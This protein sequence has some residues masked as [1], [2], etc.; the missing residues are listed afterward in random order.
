M[1][2]PDMS[3]N[4][5]V[6]KN[7]ALGEPQLRSTPLRG[8]ECGLLVFKAVAELDKEGGIGQMQIPQSLIPTGNQLVFPE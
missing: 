6:F 7:K 1:K 4:A 2:P 5:Q 8:W 3:K